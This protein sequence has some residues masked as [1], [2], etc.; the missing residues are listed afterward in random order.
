MN[1]TYKN[2]QKFKKGFITDTLIKGVLVLLP[3]TILLIII[4]VIFNFIFDIVAPMSYI[5]HPGNQ[6]P[7]WIFSVL[8]TCILLLFVFAAGVMI[9]NKIGRA[10]FRNF[11][12]RYLKQIPLYN[13]V[14]DTVYQFSGLKKL[15]FSEVVL[16]DPFKTGTLM[17]G[18]ITDRTKNEFCTVFVPT[19]PNPTNGN[20]Y[21]VKHDTIRFLDINPHEAMRTIVGM[22][23]GSE[24]LITS[25]IEQSKENTN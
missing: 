16:I 24:A 2:N 3:I 13:L 14:Y 15:P 9:K 5:L 21:H 10:Y 11:E 6:E 23:T 22:G 12:R 25:R 19:A 4:S 8:S 1:N 7:H 18:F 20:I 17:T